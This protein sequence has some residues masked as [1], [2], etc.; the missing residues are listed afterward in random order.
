MVV[1]DENDNDAPWKEGREVA[2]K[3]NAEFVLTQNLGHN[4]TLKDEDV[5]ASVVKFLA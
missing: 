4:K 3:L 2:D 5:I 1:A